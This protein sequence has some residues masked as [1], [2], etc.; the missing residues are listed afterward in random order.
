MKTEK[1]EQGIGYAVPVLVYSVIIVAFAQ[2]NLSILAKYFTVS[3][4][5]LLLP[6]FL[7]ITKDFPL[8]P[9][10]IVSGLG[11][12]ASRAFTS[13]ALTGE[14]ANFIS[15][16]LP[17]AF[18][19]IVYGVFLYFYY[20]KDSR[21]FTKNYELPMLALIDYL[22]NLVELLLREGF[23]SL[24]I[25]NQAGIVCVAVIRAFIV[26]LFVRLI[27]GYEIMLLKHEDI[28]IYKKLLMTVTELSGETV[29]MKEN[30]DMV[31]NTMSNAYKLYDE[32]KKESNRLS[33][34][35]LSLATNVH[36]IKKIYS[37][38]LRGVSNSLESNIDR[39]GMYIS[40]I[41]SLLLKRAQD[42][43]DEEG[44]K[45]EK[46]VDCPDNLFTHKY[47]YL[48]SVFNNLFTNAVE[49]AENNGLHID[50]NIKESDGKYIMT[51]ENDGKEIPEDRIG[52]IFNAGYST[53]INYE[54]GVV[55]RGLGLLIVKNIIEKE[56]NGEISVSSV[57]GRTRFVIKIPRD[58]MEVQS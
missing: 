26:L 42:Y 6:V 41:I 22:S 15:A 21:N 19:Y 12:A 9:V 30:M 46:R 18:F 33:E 54:T 44:V 17:E 57:K 23:A 56:F 29:C 8:I 40:E 52:D 24:T 5:I 20:E 32:L 25:E 27:K 28:K 14:A 51:V 39:E 2:F 43:A 4:G 45:L 37:S 55:G 53:K 48:M 10:S 31:E 47:Y 7:T 3:M 58:E 16:Y 11:V 49:A 36:E 13:V 34:Q 38:V 35:A 1:S 50:I